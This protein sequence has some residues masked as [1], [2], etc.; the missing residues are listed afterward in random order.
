MVVRAHVRKA[1]NCRTLC[2]PP[3]LDRLL[4]NEERVVLMIERESEWLDFCDQID[5]EMASF[6]KVSCTLLIAGIPCSVLIVISV[7]S[8]FGS[9]YILWYTGMALLFLWFVAAV[10]FMQRFKRRTEEKMRDYC[11]ELAEQ[12]GIGVSLGKAGGGIGCDADYF[13]KLSNDPGGRRTAP[14]S[15]CG[16]DDDEGPDL[17]LPRRNR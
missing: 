14:P 8:R 16:D 9:R 13:V 12:S 5:R 10:I 4:E 1:N 3:R 6:F 7:M 17:E 11:D 2:C 15:V